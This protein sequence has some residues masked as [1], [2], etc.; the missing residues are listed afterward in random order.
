MMGYQM[1]VI[2]KL[3]VILALA[4]GVQTAA[5]DEASDAVQTLLKLWKG[6]SAT[7][8]SSEFV[9]DSKT[10]RMR[11]T[12]RTDDGRAYVTTS[13]APFRLL[14]IPESP[15]SAIWEDCLDA[16]NCVLVACLFER[17]CIAETEVEGD[18]ASRDPQRETTRYFKRAEGGGYVDPAD[19]HRVGRALR[20]LIELNAARFNRESPQQQPF[21]PSPPSSRP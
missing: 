3:I 13:E 9:G 5:A 16:D 19:A 2:R 8:S 18:P 12:G 11:T 15:L 1:L 10:F 17:E 21:A 4:S 6:D 14:A 20:A 7:G